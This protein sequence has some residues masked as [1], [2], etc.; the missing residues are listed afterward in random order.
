[1]Y[2]IAGLALDDSEGEAKQ[3]GTLE[4]WEIGD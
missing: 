4:F 2:F 1:M 3:S